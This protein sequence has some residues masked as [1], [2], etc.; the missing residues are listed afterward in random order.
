MENFLSLTILIFLLIYLSYELFFSKKRKQ[1]SDTEEQGTK[2][3]TSL[4]E[5]SDG[6][7]SNVDN[8]KSVN[9]DINGSHS[10]SDKTIINQGK[11]AEPTDTI[12]AETIERDTPE[13]IILKD[14]LDKIDK[15]I[16]EGLY[17]KSNKD[18][19]LREIQKIISNLK[20]NN[21]HD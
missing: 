4:N 14:E 13:P 12:L 15:I 6:S 21:N 8:D 1:K 10:A 11:D 20:S 9:S 3:A 17:G 18:L 7:I 2:S 19:C 16:T 5:T